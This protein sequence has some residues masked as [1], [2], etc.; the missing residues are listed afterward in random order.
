MADPNTI[1]ALAKDISGIESGGDYSAL[2]PKL[3]TGDRAHGKYQIMGNNIP[4]WTEEAGL[5]RVDP[6][7]FLKN[8]DIQEKTARFKLNQLYDKYQ[9]PQDVASVW[10]SGVPLAQAKAEGRQDVLGTKTVDYASRVGGEAGAETP[11]PPTD[12]GEKVKLPDGTIV[13]LGVNPTLEDR[14]AF[15]AAI[16]KKWPELDPSAMTTSQTTATSDT[17]AVAPSMRETS[18]EETGREINRGFGAPESSGLGKYVAAIGKPVTDAVSDFARGASN[19]TQPKGWMNAVNSVIDILHPLAVPAEAAGNVTWQAATDAGAS[20]DV[21]AALATA[22]NL[23]VGA[24]TPLPE[25]IGVKPREMPFQGTRSSIRAAETVTSKATQATTQAERAAAA[26]GAATAKAGPSVEAATRATE[27]LAPAGVAPRQGA[28]AL[29]AGLEQHLKE[30][31]EPTQGIYNAYVASH[32]HEALDPAKYKGI[33]EQ[34]GDLNTAGR[35]KGDAGKTIEDLGAKINAGQKVTVADLDNYKRALDEVLPGGPKIGLS[36]KERDLYDFKFKIRELMRESA[37]GDEKEWLNAAD[38]IWRDVIIGKGKPRALGNLVKLVKKDPET[39]L[40]R[41][42]GTG[43]S[44]KQG[45]MATAV[46][47]HLEGHPGGADEALRQAMG[48]RLIKEAS[49][50]EGTTLDPPALLKQYDNLDENVRNAFFNPGAKAFFKTEREIQEGAKTAA[51]TASEASKA[52]KAA[53][54]ASSLAARKVAKPN[55][56]AKLTAEGLHFTL[57]GVPLEMVGRHLGMPGLGGIGGVFGRRMIIPPADIAKFL[58]NSKTANLFARALRTPANSAVVPAIL[59]Q[60]R[61]SDV[62]KKLLAAPEGQQKQE[63]AKQ[64]LA[65]GMK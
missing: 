1:D 36:L 49:D 21:A 10:H 35:L 45:E 12:D 50:A 8:P 43:A 64:M 15:K 32:G 26:S 60:L 65:G 59:R 41:L 38:S 55:M 62:G 51:E 24:K 40:T 2:G 53:T 57:V 20:P 56:L 27:A 5:G 34:I 22:V 33:A 54:S 48:M 13:N 18:L 37:T 63:E 17:P 9:N 31:K 4:A 25:G 28:Q 23:G 42:F 47:K 61:D 14:T 39:A 46:M 30:V 58:A 6:K 19:I 3:K 11:V 16:F 7:S 44:E 52:A 29:E